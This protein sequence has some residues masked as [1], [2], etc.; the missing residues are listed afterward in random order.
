MR[1]RWRH[2]PSRIR[3]WASPF[4]SALS[5]AA[6]A[7]SMSIGNFSI[8]FTWN[9]ILRTP[10]LLAAEERQA[11]FVQGQAEARRTRHLQLEVAIDRRLGDDF[12]GKQQRAEQL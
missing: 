4:A 7:G 12:F 6:L 2:L 9:S 8:I 11:L 5:L 3:P 10:V 1:Q